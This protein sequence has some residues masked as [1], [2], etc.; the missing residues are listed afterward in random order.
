MKQKISKQ[1]YEDIQD[2]ASA[3]R[4]F[5][6]NPRFQFIRDYLSVAADDIERKILNNTIREVREVHTINEKFKQIFITP[7]KL[8]VDELAGAYKFIN[9]FM[10]DMN[11]FSQTKQELE[12][13]EANGVVIIEKDEKK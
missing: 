11:Q 8:A 3:A 7:K 5:L 12:E 2:K 6:T 4:Y 10:D 13:A 1:E 9:Q